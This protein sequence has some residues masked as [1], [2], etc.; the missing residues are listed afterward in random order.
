M[1]HLSVVRQNVFGGQQENR[2]LGLNR[3]FFTINHFSLDPSI[4]MVPFYY[5]LV[6]LSEQYPS[7]LTI[8][9]LHIKIEIEN[10]KPIV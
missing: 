2:R 10:C 8:F 9:V 3:T 1:I 4:V 7:I 6:F 5:N